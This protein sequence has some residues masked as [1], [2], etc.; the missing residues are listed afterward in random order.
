MTKARLDSSVPPG[1]IEPSALY[2]LGVL[3][4]R[5]GLGIAAIRHMRREGLAVRY[6]AGRA[7]VRG[8]DFIEFVEQNGK[9]SKNE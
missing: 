8:S 2:P 9:K 6:V 1:P 7:F 5:T 4:A 3:R